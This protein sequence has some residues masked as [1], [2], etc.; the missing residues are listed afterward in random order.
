M[1]ALRSPKPIKE[2]DY[3]DE[4]VI[5][6]ISG[7]RHERVVLRVLRN[8][9]KLTELDLG[10]ADVGTEVAGWLGDALRRNI[11]PPRRSHAQTLPRHQGRPV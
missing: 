11:C 10:G 1:L 4:K 7:H 2:A 5:T 9:P 8:D 3:V 6:G